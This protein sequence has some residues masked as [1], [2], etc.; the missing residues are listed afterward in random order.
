MSFHR[1]AFGFSEGGGT[2]G[3][4]GGFAFGPG[5]PGEPIGNVQPILPDPFGAIPDVNDTI[6]QGIRDV[7]CAA[8]RAILCSNPISRPIYETICGACGT[9]Q[10]DPLDPGGPRDIDRLVEDFGQQQPRGTTQAGSCVPCGKNECVTV[11]GVNR[12]GNPITRKGRLVVDPATGNAICV[13]K[14]RRMNPMNAQANRRS[15]SRLK[16]AHREA[17]KIIDT[18]DKFAKPR[19]SK[20]PSSRRAAASCAC[21]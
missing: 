13:P 12:C 11:T 8:G 21:K 15:M 16:G 10:V 1:G 5:G 17:K 14:K 3:G 9:P 20:A 4:D 18:L 6:A 7:G 19:R 2:F